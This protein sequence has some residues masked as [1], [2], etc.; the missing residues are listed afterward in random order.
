MVYIRLGKLYLPDAVH[1]SPFPSVSCIHKPEW[2]SFR[3]PSTVKPALPPPTINS[4]I[5]WLKTAAY[6]L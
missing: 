1:M 5:P 4:R 6:N 3:A 2:E